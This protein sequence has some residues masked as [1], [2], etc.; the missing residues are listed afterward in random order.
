[1]KQGTMKE[2]ISN[3]HARLLKTIDTHPVL[4]VPAFG[5]YVLISIVAGM[6]TLVPVLVYY[7]IFSKTPVQLMEAIFVVIFLLVLLLIWGHYLILNIR[8]L[9]K[10]SL[11]ARLNS[12]IYGIFQAVLLSIFMF[13]VIYYY[14]QLFTNNEAISGI[15]EIDYNWKNV[16]FYIGGIFD[17]LTLIPDIETVVDCIYFSLVTISTLG[18]GEM[19]PQTIPAKIVVIAEVILGF[20]L[21]AIS[22]GTV[23]SNS[24]LTNASSRRAK[25][26]RG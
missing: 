4:L 19:L 10:H 2:K 15:H 5:I 7:E 25:G 22:I 23:I 26:T 21:M 13:G 14:L 16:G 9:V 17:K 20:V 12:Q 11:I 6:I 8:A 18:Y 1:M 24:E 3:I